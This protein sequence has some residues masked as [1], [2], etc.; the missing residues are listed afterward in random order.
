MVIRG[1]AFFVSCL[2]RSDVVEIVLALGVI[3]TGCVCY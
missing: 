2:V 3:S 1:I